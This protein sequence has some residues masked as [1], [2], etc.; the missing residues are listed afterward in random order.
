[1]NEL[2]RLRMRRAHAKYARYCSCGKIVHGNGGKTSHQA[3]HERNGTWRDP[4]ATITV[5]EYHWRDGNFVVVKDR[6]RY[7]APGHTWITA[8]DY[9]AL[10]AAR[11][12]AS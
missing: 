12:E 9:R 7:T 8:D 11:E 3:G 2:V 5:P 1:M 10:F 4:S 6:A